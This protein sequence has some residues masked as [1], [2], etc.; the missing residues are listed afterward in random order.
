M[1]ATWRGDLLALIAGAMLPLAFA[2][3]DLYPLAIVSLAIL[4]LLWLD[5]SVRRAMWRGLLFGVGMFGVGVSWVFISMHEYGYVSFALSLF[6]TA[7]FV[8]VLSLFIALAAGFAHR[9]RQ[10]LRLS[11]TAALIYCFPAVWV[12]LEWVRGWMFTGFPWL[13]LGYSQIDTPL[14]GYAPLLGVYGVS[15]AVA[16][17]AA[18][19]AAVIRSIHY[20]EK[21]NY[22]VGLAPLWLIGLLAT[23]VPWVSPAGDPLRV[24]LV[25]GNIPQEMKW[26]PSMRA[27]T[28]NLYAELTR[29]NWD[30]DLVIWPETALPAFFHESTSFLATLGEE[31]RRHNTDILLGLVYLDSETREYYNTMMSIGSEIGFYHKRH[32]VPFTEYLPL[33]EWLAT[34]INI[35]QVPMSDFSAGSHDQPPLS[36]AGQKVGISICFEDA[37]GEEVIMQLPQATMLVNVSNDAWFADSSAPHQ[38][39]QI[40]RMRA[41]ESGR[42]MLRATNTGISAIIDHHGK[43]QSRAP[44]FTEATLSSEVLPMQGATPYVYLGNIGILVLLLVQLLLP[45]M[46]RR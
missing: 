15:L 28:I 46:K 27:P 5:G 25:Q 21:S 44:Q 24:T 42:P 45:L 10:C 26:L 32:L 9:L 43:F 35:I 11:P 36:V 17:S 40:A 16:L 33:K 30:S 2:P 37:F 4:F 38:H 23:L 3:Y 14:G 18:V 12:L 1:F 31:A 29:E 20:G 41:R 22:I 7:L 39:L 6:L 13:S 8:V 19:I 34:V